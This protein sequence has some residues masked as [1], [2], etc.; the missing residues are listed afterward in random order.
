MNFELSEEQAAIAQ[1]ASGLFNGYCSDMHLGAFDASDAPFMEQLWEECVN[2]GLHALALPEVHGGSG[3]GMTELILVLEAQGQALAQIPLW[4]HQLTAAVLM[5]FTEDPHLELLHAAVSGQIMLTLDVGSCG[6]GSLLRAYRDGSGWRLRGRVE[7]LALGTVARHAVLMVQAED[8]MRLALVDLC[9]AGI[10]RTPGRLCHGEAVADVR[11]SDIKLPETALLPVA[12]LEWLENRAIAALAA[13][14]LGV[15]GEQVRRAVD[16]VN[17]RRQFDRVIGSFQAVQ[18]TLADTYIAIEA[19][20]SSLW[21]LVYRLDAG[22][23]ATSQALAVRY[24]ACETGHLVGHKAQHVHGGVGVDLSYPIHRY[25]YWSRA[26]GSALGGAAPSLEHLGHWLA[27][28]DT[29]GWKY[30]LEEHP[31]IC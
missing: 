31:S 8:V 19:L 20:R 25:L 26:L 21:Q 17:E 27:E 24:L 12:A 16:Y 11:C 4:R 18:M 30:D 29:L 6:R 28:N 14:Q 7:A 2:V 1:M 15:S 13:L 9:V 23:A 10:D 22:L 3:L 5:Q